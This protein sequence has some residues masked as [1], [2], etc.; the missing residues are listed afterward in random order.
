MTIYICLRFLRD[1]NIKMILIKNSNFHITRVPEKKKMSRRLTSSLKYCKP[2][3]FATLKIWAFNKFWSQEV[4]DKQN[5]PLITSIFFFK[6]CKNLYNRS[7][8]FYTRA[9]IAPHLKLQ[10]FLKVDKWFDK[11]SGI[12][13]TNY[14]GKKNNFQNSIK[15][16]NPNRNP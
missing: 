5:P 7:P 3:L 2:W 12:N 6:S 1:E 16:I 13:D 4:A 8:F 11:I 15:Y 14:K 9:D 10:K